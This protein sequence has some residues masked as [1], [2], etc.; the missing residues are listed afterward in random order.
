MNLKSVSLVGCG[1]WGRNILKVLD[2]IPYL[3]TVV[4]DTNINWDQPLGTEEKAFNVDAVFIASPAGLHYEHVK[5]ALQNGCHVF[6]EKPMALKVHQCVEL[7]MLAEEKNLV[8]MVGH[9]LHYHEGFKKMK[10]LINKGAIGTVRTVKSIQCGGTKRTDCDAL[11]SLAPHYVSQILAIKGFVEPGDIEIDWNDSSQLRLFRVTGDNG[12][13]EIENDKLFLN[14]EEVPYL[15]H[16]LPLT[17]EI[18]TFVSAI[19]HGNHYL[20][21]GW[22]GA[23]VMDAIENLRDGTFIHP[24]AMMEGH[25][26]KGSKVWHNSHICKGA[27]IGKNV[28]IGQNVFIGENVMIGRDCRIQNNVSIFDGVTIGNGVFI[29][30]GTTFTNV[31]RPNTGV[32]AEYEKTEVMGGSTIGANST[33]ICGTTIGLRAFIG[34]GSVVT[35]DVPSG[36]TV[37][38]VPAE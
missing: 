11:Q 37:M 38:G 7:A 29:G 20:N 15:Q 8:L 18:R 24:T 22:E 3:K 12:E 33:I 31:K 2:E 32:K 26:H 27:E 23:K 1:N 19:E 28:T 21:D 10:K 34:A 35:K 14:F 13:I 16:A 30:P 6:V 36:N 17:M 25:F 9:I 4:Y 5:R